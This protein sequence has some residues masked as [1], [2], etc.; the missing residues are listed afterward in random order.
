MER[1]RDVL[2]VVCPA[3]QGHDELDVVAAV[4]LRLELVA[5]DRP[6]RL[7]P[8]SGVTMR[9]GHVPGHTPTST[10]SSMPAVMSRPTRR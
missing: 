2:G 3:V 5:P 1:A 9:L 8:E 7:D 4:E 10:A 6:D